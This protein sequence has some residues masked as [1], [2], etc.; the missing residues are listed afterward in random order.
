MNLLI[1]KRMLPCSDRTLLL[2]RS[3]AHWFLKAPICRLFHGSFF[4]VL[5]DQSASFWMKQ[6]QEVIAQ[7]YHRG[8]PTRS[9]C[10]L[11]DVAVAPLRVD[12]NR[13]YYMEAALHLKVKQWQQRHLRCFL[14]KYGMEFRKW[15][16]DTNKRRQKKTLASIKNSSRFMVYSHSNSEK[17]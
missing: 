9:D 13:D 3:L 17:R 14:A 7:N 12:I 11:V 6:K 1:L 2:A 16:V 4:I 10:K 5:M 8:R 15:W